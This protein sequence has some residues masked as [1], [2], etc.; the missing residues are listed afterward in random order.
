MI[1]LKNSSMVSDFSSKSSKMP[2]NPL[3]RSMRNAIK[4]KVALMMTQQQDRESPEPIHS[5]DSPALQKDKYLKKLQKKENV[6][7]SAPSSTCLIDPTNDYK[8]NWD[9]FIT[10]VLLFSCLVTPVQIALLDSVDGAQEVMNYVIDSLFL[11]D[12]LLIFNTALQDDDYAIIQDRAL[13]CKDYLQGWFI[14]D[15]VAI[16]PL[17]HMIGG[18]EATNL[19]RYTRIGRIT[20]I[21]R[22][23]KL[24]R[25][26]KLQ[27]KSQQF[28]LL[29]SIQ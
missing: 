20:K 25:L 21:L 8:V 28:S 18:G 29:D 4:A 14:I 2:D 16:L 27:K 17:E 26:I 3:T 19:V 22:L 11:I 23:V 5:Q 6:P 10:A 9:I 13:I 24:L 12:I 7:E 15:V 1:Q